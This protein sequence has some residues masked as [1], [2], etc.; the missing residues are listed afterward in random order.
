MKR[1]FSI[2]TIILAS[3]SLSPR[4]SAE[5]QYFGIRG[6]FPIVNSSSALSVLSL[7]MI[8]IQGG[9]NFVADGEAGFGLRASLTTVLLANRIGVD[10]LYLIPNDVAGNG[11]YFGAG[12]DA[13]FVVNTSV[14]FGAHG[15]AGY[16]FAVSNSLAV[17][18]E[19][20]AGGLF[21]S[22]ISLFNL[23]FSAGLNF[24]I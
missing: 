8:G 5:S 3:F 11:W 16:N 4:A 22:G 17:F 20:F 14:L 2:I 1:I 10:A 15:L 12:S 9:Y 13:V 19:A 21:S 6:D 24:R 18:T 7:P 23:G